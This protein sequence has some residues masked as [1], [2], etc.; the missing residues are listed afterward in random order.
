[1]SDLELS[2]NEGSDIDMSDDDVSV[3]KPTFTKKKMN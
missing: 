3:G 2:E 1:M